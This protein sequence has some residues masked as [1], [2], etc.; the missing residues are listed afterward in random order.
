MEQ[1]AELMELAIKGKKPTDYIKKK[2]RSLT[3]DFKT[4]R[5]VL[6]TRR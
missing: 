4:P 6:R 1:I 5:Y 3:K 2:V